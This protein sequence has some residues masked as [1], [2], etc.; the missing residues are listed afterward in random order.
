MNSSTA[1]RAQQTGVATFETDEYDPITKNVRSL[2][3]NRAK[4]ST[5]PDIDAICDSLFHEDELLCDL[6]PDRAD[7][8]TEA[9]P[10]FQASPRHAVQ[11]RDDRR[12]RFPV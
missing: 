8:S 4:T 9:A 2:T 3:M 12:P 7:G 1:E 10:S 6:G 5:G 11:K